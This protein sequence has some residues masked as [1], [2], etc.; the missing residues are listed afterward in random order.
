MDRD[1]QTAAMQPTRRHVITSLAAAAALLGPTHVLTR[2]ALAAKEAA[3]NGR[4]PRFFSADE[5]ELLDEIAE[6]IIPA[7]AR[8]GGAR[9]AGVAR[10]LDERIAESRDPAWRKSWRDDLAEIDRLSR[11]S[12]GKR[13]VRATPEQRNEIMQRISRNEADPQEPGEYAFGTIKWSV[14]DVYYRTRIGI[15]DDLEYRGNVML[16]EFAGTDVSKRG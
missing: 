3:S 8:S 12:F 9:L 14:A 16:D 5:L 10:I 2:A 6:T 7:D 4:T 15:H 13:Y 1:R 11:L